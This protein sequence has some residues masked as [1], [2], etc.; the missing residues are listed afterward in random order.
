MHQV[1]QKGEEGFRTWRTNDGFPARPEINPGGESRPP[2]AEELAQIQQELQQS[3]GTA[4]DNEDD[5][6]AA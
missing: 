3:Q 2:T 4:D 6:A 1:Y 5:T